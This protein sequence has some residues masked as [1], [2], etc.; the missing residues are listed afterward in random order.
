ML[1]D[2]F[3]I[4]AQIVNFAVLAI[5]LKFLLYDR[6]VRAMD[7]REAGIA[8]RLQEA[9]DHREEADERSRR[10]H[11]R[12]REL[13]ERADSM[14]DEARHE[15]QEH[16]RELL[17]QAR[18]QVDEQRERWQRVLEQERADLCE[19]LQRRTAVVVVELT[20]TALAD[21]AD[22][23]LESAVVERALQHLSDDDS[24]Q[25]AFFGEGRAGRGHVVVR[26]ALPLE[27]QRES[28]LERIRDLTRDDAVDVRFERDE[29]L[30]L[31]VELSANGTALDW[32][33]NDY[34]DRLESTIDELL[35]EVL[36]RVE[37]NHGG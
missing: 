27:G 5:A 13:E 25:E 7:E 3:T 22:T 12:E 36:G 17:T 31:G 32:N 1:L 35:D 8:Q 21:L 33:A 29:R 20:R 37:E 9:D 10:L 16:R 6:V 28:V 15:A 18:Q 30:I 24:A 23:D 26:S 14:L 2:P 4:V 19:E 34:L 11:D